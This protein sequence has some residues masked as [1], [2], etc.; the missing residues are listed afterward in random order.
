[1]IALL[2]VVLGALILLV[3]LARHHDPPGSRSCG[4]LSIVAL[5]GR[6]LVRDLRSHPANFP[7][8]AG[9][10]GAQLRAPTSEAHGRK[11]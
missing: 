11:G 10:H 8:P 6:R 5:G 3:E 9:A 2:L 4:A 1:M 7:A